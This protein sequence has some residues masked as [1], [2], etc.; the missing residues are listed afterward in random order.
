MP[1]IEVYKGCGTMIPITEAKKAKAYQCPW[2]N[3]I[4]ATKKSYVSHLKTLRET[5]M[6]TRARN[7]IR[8]KLKQELWNQSS[9]NDVIKW[10]SLHPDFMYT[11]NLKRAWSSDIETLKKLRDNFGVEIT[12]LDLYWKDSCHNTHECP[13]NGVTNWGGRTLLKDGTPAPRGHPGWYGRIEFKSN[14]SFFKYDT[15]R[16][17]RIF[18]GSGSGISGNRYGYSVTFFADDWPEIY[19]TH[20]EHMI[21][22]AICD[23]KTKPDT[24]VF[25]YG[26]SVY[27][28]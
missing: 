13:H 12:Y 24:S 17:L 19:K 28:R 14:T 23:I 15:M 16:S 4:Y 7:I 8:K 6:H 9:F 3:K 2:T 21:E 18:T 11:E 26:N 1:K 20:K 27:F 25:K 22:N 10:I 5:R